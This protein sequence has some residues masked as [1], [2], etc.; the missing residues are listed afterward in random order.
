MRSSLLSVCAMPFL[1]S[2]TMSASG[3]D[4]LFVPETLVGYPIYGSI[5]ASDRMRITVV[6]F[7]T[8]LPIPQVEVTYGPPE[9]PEATVT[10]DENGEIS[11]LESASSG[12]WDLHLFHPLYNR[13]SWLGA[14]V[15]DCRIALEPTGT[16]PAPVGPSRPTLPIRVQL[17]SGAAREFGVWARG[18]TAFDAFE[19]LGVFSAGAQEVEVQLPQWGGGATSIFAG[20]VRDTSPAV[21]PSWSN[22][23]AWGAVGPAS[24][25]PASFDPVQPTSVT[26]SSVKPGLVSLAM[27]AEIADGL[28]SWDWV[29]WTAIQ[30]GSARYNGS[31]AAVD[32]ARGNAGLTAPELDAAG[33]D[34][35]RAGLSALRSDGKASLL[36]VARPAGGFSYSALPFLRRRELERVSH[37]QWALGPRDPT[38]NLTFFVATTESDVWSAIVFDGRAA[39][40]LPWRQGAG[41]QG[42]DGGGWDGYINDSVYAEPLLP[43]VPERQPEELGLARTIVR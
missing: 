31:L 28:E 5:R 17:P 16:P 40:E 25:G 9:A 6:D 2:C 21:D 22:V 43:W 14:P 41:G 1:G 18:A 13:R 15:A 4:R 35:L 10:T 11:V 30:V 27:P 39:I 23:F 34:G 42:S 29:A 8:D 7:A 3:L 20:F 36:R 24:F 19:R 26:M 38:A 37:A 32:P 33:R 12:S